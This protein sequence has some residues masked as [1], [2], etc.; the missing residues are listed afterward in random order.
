VEARARSDNEEVNEVTKMG[1][2]FCECGKILDRQEDGVLVCSNGHKKIDEITISRC[3]N[4][5]KQKIERERRMITF[6]N[7]EDVVVFR[8]KLPDYIKD[9]RREEGGLVNYAESF[10]AYE[11][12]RKLEEEYEPT[13]F[14]YIRGNVH[15]K[16]GG[17][18]FIR[19]KLV[20]EITE[21]IQGFIMP[22]GDHLDLELFNI[23][24]HKKKELI[25]EIKMEM[26]RKC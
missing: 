14:R 26:K 10:G 24:I 1:L 20:S 21:K 9:K 13:D 6:P 8:L 17:L 18:I 12:L 3:K 16:E 19:C 11:N 5:E 2:E 25:K 15:R 4:R 7:I 23:S 22:D